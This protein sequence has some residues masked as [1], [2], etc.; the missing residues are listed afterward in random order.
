M[1]PSKQN[2]AIGDKHFRLYIE[3]KEIDAIVE[4]VAAE[5]TRD[6][7]NGLD[8]QGRAPILLPVLNGAYMFAADLSRRLDFDAEICFVK[9]ASYEGTR[10]TGRVKQLIG[11]PEGLKDRNVVV[12]EDI[13]D[14]GISM[15][16]VLQQLKSLGV[17]SARLCTFLF[18]PG[19][20]QEHYKIDYVGKEIEDDF[21]VGYGMDYKEKGR[22]YKDIYI[23]D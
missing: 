17:A 10:S 8:A 2:I 5:L 23:V 6:Y 7:A 21:I 19:K 20:F 9:M 11:F 22:L 13:I 15:G 12:V 16:Q 18:K 14:T 1:E 3:R 4:R